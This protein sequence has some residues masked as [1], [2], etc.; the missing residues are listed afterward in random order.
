MHFTCLQ[1]YSQ[2][3]RKTITDMYSTNITWSSYNPVR[4][5]MDS[6]IFGNVSKLMQKEQTYQN[7]LLSL[8]K[9]GTYI[10]P[11]CILTT[12]NPTSDLAVLC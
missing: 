6:V 9:S 10:N 3:E 12:A 7:I 2:Y 8:S 5:I 4:L 1:M 11:K